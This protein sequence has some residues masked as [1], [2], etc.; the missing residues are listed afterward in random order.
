MTLAILR[1]GAHDG[2]TTEVA[3]GVTRLV[4]VSDAPGL[5]DVYELV[6]DETHVPAD[7]DDP[8][9]VFEFSAQEPAT[10]IA[11]EMLHMP[12][13]AYGDGD[14]D[15]DTAAEAAVGSAAGATTRGGLAAGA[16]GDVYVDPVDLRTAE[17]AAHDA[18]QDV[19]QP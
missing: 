9:L 14:G 16:D 12:A 3:D 15:G 13:P 6:D 1:G 17:L 7:P 5:L 2:K 11:P 4:T 18:G 8:E 19:E 10:D